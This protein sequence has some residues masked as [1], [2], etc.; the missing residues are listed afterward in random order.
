MTPLTSLKGLVSMGHGTWPILQSGCIS[1]YDL[2]KAIT[3]KGEMQLTSTFAALNES[4]TVTDNA[5]KL[6][7]VSSKV[8]SNCCFR[9][10]RPSSL[11]F[12]LLLTYIWLPRNRRKTTAYLEI[13]EVC[14]VFACALRRKP[15]DLGSAGSLD[16]LNK[17]T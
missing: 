6:K 4:K 17:G 9:L 3:A 13:V 12:S 16:T 5:T 2:K 15:C 10:R 1:L 14:L 8:S 11:F 7:P